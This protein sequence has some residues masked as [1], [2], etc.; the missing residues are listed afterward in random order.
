MCSEVLSKKFPVN[1]GKIT[2][3]KIQFCFQFSYRW[4]TISKEQ[5][6]E[7]F[8]KIRAVHG[9]FQETTINDRDQNCYHYVQPE[10]QEYRLTL[11]VS[12]T[13]QFFKLHISL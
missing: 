8:R 6:L 11:L 2:R 4:K 7:S 9:F 5:S 10:L 3:W 13:R 1:I 12:Q